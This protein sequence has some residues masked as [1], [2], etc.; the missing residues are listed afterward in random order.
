VRSGF[1]LLEVLVA[2]VVAAILSLALT[3]AQQ[4]AFDLA[5]MAAD[6]SRAMDLAVTVMA[7]AR[8]GSMNLPTGG[9]IKRATPPEGE[10]KMEH[11]SDA[12]GGW[13]VFTVR[14]G[15]SQMVWEWP[16]TAYT[17]QEL[18]Q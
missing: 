10:W 2:L 17:G 16:D 1:T 5:Q 14:A 13:Q 11:E 15:D 18:L 4:R 3:A 6:R 7:E 8:L 9:F 12:S